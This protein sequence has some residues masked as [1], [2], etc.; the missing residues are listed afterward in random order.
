VSGCR[1][2]ERLQATPIR[3]IEIVVGY[4]AASWSLAVAGAV[5]LLYTVF[6]LNI[7]YAGNLLNI[8]VVEMLL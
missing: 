3:P 2:L 8:F 7:H 5:T 1:T 6:V 4:M